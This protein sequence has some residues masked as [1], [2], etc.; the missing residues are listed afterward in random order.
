MKS[1][2][3]AITTGS[4]SFTDDGH[5]VNNPRPPPVAHDHT[6]QQQTFLKGFLHS[7]P[8]MKYDELQ[9]I[10]NNIY[11]FLSTS[12]SSSIAA[13]AAAAAQLQQ[14]MDLPSNEHVAQWN[15]QAIHSFWEEYHIR[16]CHS[17][18]AT[19]ADNDDRHADSMK[20]DSTNT[21]TATTSGTCSIISTAKE[22]IVNHENHRNYTGYVQHLQRQL[23][24][25]QTQQYGNKPDV[26]ATFR[27]TIQDTSAQGAEDSET[28]ET[29]TIYTH[30]IPKMLV[31]RTFVEYIDTS[32]Y[33]TGSW[34]GYWAVTIVDELS[35]NITGSI[36]IRTHTFE[37]NTNS[38]TSCQQHYSNGDIVSLQ[39]EMVN[40]FVAKFERSTM[41]YAEKLAM[42]I[43]HYITTKEQ[44]YYTT[45]DD[46]YSNNN[47]NDN[48]SSN[49]SLEYQL[50][51]IRRI[52]PITKTK[53]QWQNNANTSTQQK[54]VQL[55]FM[56]NLKTK[57]TK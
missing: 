41:S 36:Q 34:E 28:I 19:A 5:D 43:I 35:A 42:K 3:S 33:S 31:I 37:N 15:E 27:V 12:S 14:R 4:M 40:S 6:W 9:S 11:Q 2:V 53:F 51:S 46:L 52:L 47:N 8:P 56:H 26:S 16:T 20:S 50:R 39:E 13:A 23:Q 55:Q 45:M 57:N 49:A 48:N 44:D 18:A 7:L 38:Q 21:T 25:Y 29:K 10:V 54:N 24:D 32:N 17:H 30:T 1:E 22:S